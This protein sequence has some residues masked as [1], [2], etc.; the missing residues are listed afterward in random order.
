MT[1]RDVMA[2]AIEVYGSKHQL[3]KAVEE[4]SE[5]VVELSKNI[6]GLKSNVP[7]ELADVEI[8]L[9]QVKMILKITPEH[10]EVFKCNKLIRL[11]NKLEM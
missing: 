10:L 1:G 4:L 11:A 5:L 7:E 9:E 6:N 8:M 2:R 3:V